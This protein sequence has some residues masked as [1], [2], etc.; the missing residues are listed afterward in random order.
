ME[1]FTYATSLDLNMGYYHIEI[2][3][4]SRALRRIVLPLGKYK[5]LKL[6]MGLCNSPNIFQ[7]EMSKIFANIE[8][9]RATE[10]KQTEILFGCQELEYLGYWVTK[11]G[12][13]PL[14]KKVEAILK[15]TTPTTRKQLHCFIDMINYYCNMWQ[16]CSKVLAP[17]AVLTS[18]IYTDA[19]DTQ[20][21]AVIGQRGM[22]IAFYLC[23]LNCAQKNYTTTE[24]ELLTIM[25]T[26][27]EFK[28]ILL[29]QQIK[30]YTNHKT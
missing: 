9:V 10:G 7:E 27:K 6:P 30:I 8:E 5:Y 29:G 15:I 28:N 24:Q 11:Q 21:G 1:G 26:L 13:K 19:S 4:V 17:L 12:I 14:Q 2:L 16:G 20:F 22:P 25:E 18:K 3:P 23:N